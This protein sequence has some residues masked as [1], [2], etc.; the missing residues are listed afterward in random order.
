MH[1]LIMRP[2]A[3]GDTL[4][5][6]PVILALK[7][8]YEYAHITLVGNPAV[9]PLAQIWGVAD[10]AADYGDAKWSEL[11]STAGIG[12]SALHRLLQR[13]DI[14]ICWLHDTDGVV[15]HNLLAAGIRRVIVAPG[16]PPAGMRVHIVEYLGQTVGMA[17]DARTVPLLPLLQSG[18]LSTLPTSIAIHPGS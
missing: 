12:S 7:A 13:T 6:F 16:R 3:I 5:T 8:G 9:L 11:F 15:K 10:E 2:G 14:A 1:I 4:L 18:I 17:I